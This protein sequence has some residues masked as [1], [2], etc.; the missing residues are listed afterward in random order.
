MTGKTLGSL[1]SIEYEM[2][3]GSCTAL[4]PD[5]TY[6]WPDILERRNEGFQPNPP[7]EMPDCEDILRWNRNGVILLIVLVVSVSLFLW[8]VFG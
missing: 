7:P 3:A 4:Y 1:G 2:L 5:P 8:M 6:G